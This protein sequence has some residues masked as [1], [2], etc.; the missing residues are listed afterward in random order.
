MG[1]IST[2][3]PNAARRAGWVARAWLAESGPPDVRE[4][5]ISLTTLG[6]PNT[7]PKEDAGLWTAVDQTRGLLKYINGRFPG[8]HLESVRYASVVGTALQGEGVRA[9]KGQWEGKLA[10]ERSKGCSASCQ[11][12][13]KFL[14]SRHLL[15]S[16]AFGRHAW[17]CSVWV[18]NTAIRAVVNTPRILQILSA[19]NPHDDS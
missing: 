17:S 10:Y 8:A 2:P 14:D 7:S 12:R 6:T 9:S 5:I 11:R 1:S 19:N 4:K 3:Q 18:T 16:S 13:K 15:R